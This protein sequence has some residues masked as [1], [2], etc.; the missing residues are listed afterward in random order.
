MFILSLNKIFKFNKTVST[1]DVGESGLY[2]KKEYLYIL[3]N[4]HLDLPIEIQNKI[5]S[6]IGDHP[7]SINYEK[8]S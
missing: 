7:I 3:L 4:G 5:Y 1:N 2:L 8:V 6:F